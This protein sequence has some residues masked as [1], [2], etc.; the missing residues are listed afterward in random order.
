MFKYHVL[1]EKKCRKSCPLQTK[2]IS[3]QIITSNKI[4]LQSLIKIKRDSL[5]YVKLELKKIPS[6]NIKLFSEKEKSHYQNPVSVTPDI[7]KPATIK[8]HN[9]YPAPVCKWITVTEVESIT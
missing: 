6:V 2:S 1:L 5:T 9:S 7:Y 8:L 3:Y 4:N